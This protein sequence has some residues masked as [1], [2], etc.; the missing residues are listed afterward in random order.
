MFDFIGAVG[1][2]TEAP[3][4][5]FVLKGSTAKFTCCSDVQQLFFWEVKPI[6]TQSTAYIYDTSGLINGFRTS[7]RF[8]VTNGGN[9]GCYKLTIAD[10]T[11]EDA[12]TYTCIDNEGLGQKISWELVIVGKNGLYRFLVLWANYYICSCVIN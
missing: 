2:L 10:V 5:N 4:N 12:G 6:G 3:K 8:N 7:G 9:S 1:R 11:L